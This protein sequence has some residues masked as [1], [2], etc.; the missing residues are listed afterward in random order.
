M[1]FSDFQH[2][3]ES[4]EPPASLSPALLALWHDGRGDWHAAHE[5]AQEMHDRVG[6]HIHAYLH[7][8]EGDIGNAHYWYR[9]ASVSPATGL[10]SEEWT[11]IVTGL[12][13][14]DLDP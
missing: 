12:L 7:R 5:V 13:A 2:S 8:K 3:L 6:S 10:L 11:A 9:K 4:P 1:T 14:Q